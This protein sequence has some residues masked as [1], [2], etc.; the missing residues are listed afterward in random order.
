M[1][2]RKITE[3]EMLF[4]S[5]IFNKDIR[6]SSLI[7]F[8]LLSF[9]FAFLYCL[10]INWVEFLIVKFILIIILSFLGFLIFNSIHSIVYLNKEI[11]TCNIDYIEA[12]FKVQ[13][14]DT[15]T[16]TNDSGYNSE[17]YKVFLTN[18]FN[19]EKKKN[20]CGARRLQSD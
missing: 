10:F 3:D 15:L 16:H 17:Y 5:Q 8:V 11:N 7:I 6:N 18:I 19:D 20:L 2:K 13:S 9:F 12:E 1:K 4:I 14:K